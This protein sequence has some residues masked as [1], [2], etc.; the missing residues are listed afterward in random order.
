MNALVAAVNQYKDNPGTLIDSVFFPALA[1]LALKGNMGWVQLTWFSWRDNL[2]LA[3]L[4]ADQAKAVLEALVAYPEIEYAAEEITATLARRWP[5]QVI[6]FLGE[7]QKF[8]STKDAPRQYDALPYSVHELRKPLEAASSVLISGARQWFEEDERLFVYDGGRLLEAV[9]PNFSD[10]LREPLTSLVQT[11]DRHDI[12][13]VLAVLRNYNGETFLH[14]LCKEIVESLDTGDALVE[15]IVLILS[16]TGVVSGEFGFAEAY[17]QKKLE[18]EPWLQ[19][20][21]D[22]VRA[23]AEKYIHKLAHWIAA[24]QR[25]A[26]GSIALRKLNYD[27]PLAD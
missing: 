16:S 19:D 11:G 20:P 6:D 12:A 21:R 13:F 3:A 4:D 9:F 2:L 17:A 25:S 24:E 5:E 18:M 14:N 26:D 15:E 27:E 8:A 1:S 22:K 10:A 23:F 7:R